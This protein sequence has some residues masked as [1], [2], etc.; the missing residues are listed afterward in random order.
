[1]ILVS[2]FTGPLVHYGNIA[3]FCHRVGN[4]WPRSRSKPSVIH[5]ALSITIVM[6]WLVLSTQCPMPMYG[7]LAHSY[8][9]NLHAYLD[10]TI[11]LVRSNKFSFQEMNNWS[12][13]SLAL[14]AVCQLPKSVMLSTEISQDMC[15][16]D[17]WILL[18]LNIDSQIHEHTVRSIVMQLGMPALSADGS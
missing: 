5:I 7:L 4:L 16:S 2:E 13:K 1:M 6:A 12:Q 11:L 10:L 8:S 3:S 17:G 14:K 15:S 9:I 18:L